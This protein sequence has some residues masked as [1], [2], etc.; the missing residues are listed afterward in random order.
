MLQEVKGFIQSGW[1]DKNKISCHLRN[2]YKLKDELLV[3]NDVLFFKNKII[4]PDSLRPAMLQKLHE[5]HLG[6]EKV[7]SR[8][9]GIFYW[10][11]M[12]QQIEDFIKNAVFVKSMIEKM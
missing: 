1:P 8:A 7:K 6:I 4:V 5:G 3:C 10:P 12:S 9:R 2:Y 11:S